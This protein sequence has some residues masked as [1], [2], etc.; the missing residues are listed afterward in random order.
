MRAPALGI[1]RSAVRQA[2]SSSNAPAS[3]LVLRANIEALGSA[4][5]RRRCCADVP[6][7][8]GSP[9]GANFELVLLDPPYA[10]DGR[11]RTARSRGRR[12]SGGAVV[13]ERSRRHSAADHEVRLIDERHYGD[14]AQPPRRTIQERPATN[15]A[16]DLRDLPLRNLDV[17]SSTS[18]ATSG[19]GRESP[20]LSAF[21]LRAS[22]SG[23]GQIRQRTSTARELDR[24][25]NTGGAQRSGAL[26]REFR[27]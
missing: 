27:S 18:S 22:W 3:L 2:P 9:C 10:A 16:S 1:K 21:S 15:A 12:S 7:A 6:G 13:I 23:S 26:P 25:M 24:P 5:P 20:S 14:T 19:P 17:L 11:S 4:R 8:A